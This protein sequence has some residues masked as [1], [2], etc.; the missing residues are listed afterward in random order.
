MTEMT[1]FDLTPMEPV[2]WAKP[3]DAPD[4]LYQVKWDGVRMLAVRNEAGSRLIN[5]KGNER[6]GQYPELAS[7]A[8][9][10][11]LGSV[12]DGEVVVLQN[13]RPSFHAVLQRDLARR[14]A[15]IRAKKRQFPATYC[16]FDLLYHRGEDIR[17]LP[18][19][20]RQRLLEDVLPQ[21]QPQLQ[22]VESFA[23]GKQLFAAVEREGLEGIV[24]K[25]R[26]SK[27]RPG[28]GSDDWRKIK[29]FREANCV[30]G[31]YTK[32]QGQL[33]ALL[34]GL[35]AEDG[36]LIYVG[37]AGSGLS[38]ADWQGL[39]QFLAAASIDVP[40]FSSPPQARNRQVHWLQ[41]VLAV[42]VRFMEWTPELKLRAPVVVRFQAAADVDCSIA[43]QGV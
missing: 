18:L 27:Y 15:V 24:A 19:A 11:P 21:G 14:P 39:G 31:G 23:S 30:V 25:Q 9:G 13:G 33:S 37:A 29:S 28:K 17:G 34:L 22:L 1:Q 43:G 8:A 7:L 2:P 32:R 3:F 26:T 16:V 38:Q 36:Q 20:E 10:L 41:P 5:R 12:V 4:W 42:R 6:T 35:W 40:P